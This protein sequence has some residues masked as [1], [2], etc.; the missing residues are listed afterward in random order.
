M[1]GGTFQGK[2]PLEMLADGETD[3]QTVLAAYRANLRLALAAVAGSLDV[4]PP[5]VVVTADHGEAFGECGIFG[6]PPG[7]LL[8]ELIEVP[9]LIVKRD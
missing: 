5:R 8:P 2:T 9:Y 7:L 3:R 4:L 6:H 1:E